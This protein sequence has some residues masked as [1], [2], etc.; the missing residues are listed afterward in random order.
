MNEHE[1]RT[2]PQ[3][4]LFERFV[5]LGDSTTEGMDDPYPGSE[6]FRGWAD[7][8]AARLAT[9]NPDLHYANLAIRGRK[10]PQIREEQ[11]E[12][13]LALEPDLA[14][15]IGGVNDILRPSVELDVIAGHMEEMVSAMRE[16]G[17]TVLMLTYPDLTE[18][19]T[20]MA[21]RIRARVDAYNER[22]RR[23]ADEHSARLIDLDRLGINHPSFW[24]VDRLHANHRGHEQIA[25]AAA[26]ILGLDLDEEPLEAPEIPPK[27]LPHRLREDLVWA[28]RHLAPWIKRRMLGQSSGDGRSAKR[29]ELQAFDL[30]A[31]ERAESGS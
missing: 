26:E 16:R 30:P 22:L 5:A 10:V 2:S 31:P 3:E 19:I 6:E 7:R 24:A 23:I 29:P 18:T 15:V 8:L 17:A 13:A 28:G 4:P 27:P 9:V 11:L 20:L 14:S 25:R 12:P 1:N 21:K